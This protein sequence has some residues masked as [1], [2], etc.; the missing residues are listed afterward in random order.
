M[1]ILAVHSITDVTA[2][3][4]FAIMVLQDAI[5]T[6]AIPEQLKV[7][8][9]LPTSGAKSTSV[10]EGP[11]V[12][13]VQEYVDQLLAEWC[14]NEY[15]VIVPEHAYGF[16]LATAVKKTKESVEGAVNKTAAATSA[17]VAAVGASLNDVDSKYK[18][19]DRTA[20]AAASVSNAALE[21]GSKAKDTISAASSKAMENETVASSVNALSAGWSFLSTKAGEVGGQVVNQASALNSAV[22]GKVKQ[23]NTTTPPD[24]EHEDDLFEEKEIS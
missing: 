1:L 23:Y 22:V 3:V 9:I 16:Q 5:K 11:S 20:S 14:S 7:R 2:K 15:F 6:R 10:W 18:I 13:A 19:R 12:E 17:A 8:E 21:T 24:E 4:P